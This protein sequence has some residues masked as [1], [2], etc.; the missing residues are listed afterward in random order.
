MRW[1]PLCGGSPT[2]SG[3]SSWPPQRPMRGSA[4]RTSASREGSPTSRRWR[5][6]TPGASPSWS[7]S[8]SW[9]RAWTRSSGRPTPPRS[10]SR[11]SAGGSSD[12]L[13]AD[14]QDWIV[15]RSQR[16]GDHVVAEDRDAAIAAVRIAADAGQDQS[17]EYRVSTPSG[18]Q[19]WIRDMVHVVRGAQGPR[20]LRGLMVDVTER[21]RAEQALRRSERKYSEAFRREREAAQRL[22]ALD[23]MKNTFLEAVSHDLRTPLTSILGSALTL[24]QT[25]LNLP[26]GGRARPGR[27]D[28]GQRAEARAAAV[29][30]AGSGPAAARHRVAATP[31]HGLP[32]SW[33][34]SSVG[35]LET[36]AD[37]SSNWTSSRSPCP[38][39]PR[40]SSASSRT[41]CRTPSGTRP[42]GTGSGSARRARTAA[43]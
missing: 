19:V 23:D 11:S 18:K 27:P 13:G 33:S 40:R 12:L 39:T 16:W 8:T 31:A 41:S 42:P 1:S 38:S 24:E 10:A 15:E 5:W 36:P 7:G 2:A 9:S 17:V 35:E 21:K 30:P 29:G 22:R 14:G 28:R 25:G 20:Q 4:P 37:A 6:G 26:P 32:E 43:C 3:R 34:H